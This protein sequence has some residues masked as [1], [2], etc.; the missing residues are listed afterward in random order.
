[1]GE[2]KHT[3]VLNKIAGSTVTQSYGGAH[4]ENRVGGDINQY[5]ETAIM[6]GNSDLL[7]KAISS[8]M[9][10]TEELRSEQGFRYVEADDPFFQEIKD[11]PDMALYNIRMMLDSA[12]AGPGSLWGPSE[13]LSIGVKAANYLAELG[14]KGKSIEVLEEVLNKNSTHPDSYLQVARELYKLNQ[15]KKAL[16][17]L[18]VVLGGTYD[19]R[20]IIPVV[21]ELFSWGLKDE[22]IA[23]FESE[24]RYI[25]FKS[26]LNLAK[27]F[28]NAGK[29]SLASTIISNIKPDDLGERINYSLFL[30]KFDRKLFEE[31]KVVL[32]DQEQTDPRANLYFARY[33]YKIA[34]E[35]SAIERVD[36]AL[37]LFENESIKFYYEVERTLISMGYREKALSALEQFVDISGKS[38]PE[39][40]E[41]GFYLISRPEF[42]N[43]IEGLK[44]LGDFYDNSKDEWKITCL[45]NR[46][47]KIRSLPGV[48]VIT[49]GFANDYLSHAEEVNLDIMKTLNE[50]KNLDNFFQ[51]TPQYEGIFPKLFKFAQNVEYRTAL[52][53]LEQGGNAEL[54]KILGDLYKA[55]LQE[56]E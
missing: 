42:E 46:L 10:P 2:E 55:L 34:D 43:S 35:E 23:L 50:W 22:V 53:V 32:N 48:E 6:I 12:E 31:F 45:L 4:V 27:Q 36:Q 29:K 9:E 51:D 18:R 37:K 1:M 56:E 33:L 40:M 11:C 54:A 19:E 24:V 13:S 17:T 20:N 21:R 3:K 25:S 5:Y 30:Q 16:D 14:Y 49:A 26:A 52:S 41:V 38:T 44:I 15:P 8:V 39:A 28:A 7:H 47:I